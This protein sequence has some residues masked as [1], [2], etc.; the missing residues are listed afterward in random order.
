MVLKFDKVRIITV[1]KVGS[2][3]FLNCGYTQTKDVKH[4]HNLL[5]LKNILDT[6]KNCLII[7]GIRNPVDR[8]LSY[9]FQT[10]KNNSFNDVKT[11]KNNYSGENGYIP[12]MAKQ[13]NVIPS[14]VIDLYF[15]KDY[16]NTF[17]E[18]FDEFLETTSITSFDRDVGLSFYQLPNNN[19]IMIY[20]LEKLDKNKDL[21]VETLGIQNFK[22]V[23]D[24]KKR[25]Y[26]A[27]YEKTK[28][29]IAYTQK[30]LDNL[31]DTRI[32]KLFY[33]END[34]KQFYSKY[35]ISR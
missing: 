1:A 29:T 8:N 13:K 2:A 25:T 10:Y 3:N 28:N 5:V 22:N 24:S 35:K 14:K 9:M 27:L 11:K 17:N 33:G 21:I 23:N 4:G 15:K 32:I 20:T 30:Y 31:L 12:I 16:H 34:T 19:T 6:E 26:H 7:T 18:W